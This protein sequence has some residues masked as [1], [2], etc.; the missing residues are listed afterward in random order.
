M[1]LDAYIILVGVAFLCFLIAIIKPSW[2]LT[3]VGGLLLS[4]ALWIAHR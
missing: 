2:P 4:I 3:A 1:K